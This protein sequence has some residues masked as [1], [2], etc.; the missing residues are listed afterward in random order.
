MKQT[1]N[2]YAIICNAFKKE[3]SFIQIDTS[4]ENIRKILDCEMVESV[5]L[6]SYP[7]TYMLLDE[8]AR[9]RDI[10]KREFRLYDWDL[11]N[12]V[13]I[14]GIEGGEFTDV[15]FKLHDI[16]ENVRYG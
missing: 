13:I 4:L 3:T 2:H 15:R 8:E 1:D 16:M 12:K 5:Q 6:F 11:V 7:P 9:I 14:I 10:E